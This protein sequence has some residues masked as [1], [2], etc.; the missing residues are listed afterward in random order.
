MTSLSMAKEELF[1]KHKSNFEAGV[2]LIDDKNSYYASSIH[3]FYYSTFQ[4]TEFI[5]RDVIGISKKD[6]DIAV[7][8]Y[9]STGSG[10]RASH[11]AKIMILYKELLSLT[12]VRTANKYKDKILELKRL[13]HQSDYKNVKIDKPISGS[14]HDLCYQI[15]TTLY[16]EFKIE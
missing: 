8:R 7:N 5:I 2:L 14:A 1:Y 13:R 3:C 16:K 15:K 11:D 4:L 10:N 6:V 9:L 12:S